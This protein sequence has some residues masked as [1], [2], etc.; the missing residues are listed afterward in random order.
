MKTSHHI[1]NVFLSSREWWHCC[2]SD[3]IIVQSSHPCRNHCRWVGR[4]DQRASAQRAKSIW[5]N[6]GQRCALKRVSTLSFV[7]SRRWPQRHN[8]SA[9]KLEGTVGLW[10]QG[11]VSC[12]ECVWVL[13]A[14]FTVSLWKISPTVKTLTGYADKWVEMTHLWRSG[15]KECFYSQVLWEEKIK[16]IHFQFSQF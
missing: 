9:H 13:Q 7:L 11:F 6:P 5:R 15:A 2:I 3:L 8:L 12:K 16:A 4:S 1:L 10:Y 14:A